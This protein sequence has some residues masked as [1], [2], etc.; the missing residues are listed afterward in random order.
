MNF[1]P[2][3]QD[4]NGSV[5][6]RG[7][8][9]FHVFRERRLPSNTNDCG[10]TENAN[11]GA[12]AAH[13]GKNLTNRGYSSGTTLTNMI[14]HIHEL[15]HQMLGHNDGSYQSGAF[16]VTGPTCPPPGVPFAPLFHYNAWHKLHFG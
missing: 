2:F 4:G 5:D 11:V 9:I 14:T 13:N 6:A 12:G 10:A 1:A 15:S 8:G 3:D 16:D 7:L